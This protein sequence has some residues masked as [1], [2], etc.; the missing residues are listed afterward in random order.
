[1]VRRRGFLGGI[2]NFSNIGG[3]LRTKVR[4]RG[5]K[6]GDTGFEWLLAWLVTGVGGY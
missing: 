1:M 6:V 4:D 3:M 2:E 5:E